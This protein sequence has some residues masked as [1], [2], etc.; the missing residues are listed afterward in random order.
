VAAR[1][2]D[3]RREISPEQFA[4]TAL[5]LLFDRIGRAQDVR[6]AQKIER[7]ASKASSTGMCA[8]PRAP[9]DPSA[10]A[11]VRSFPH[12]FCH[13][14]RLIRHGGSQTFVPR[15]AARQA[16]AL[17]LTQRRPGVDRHFWPP[18][19]PETSRIRHLFDVYN[20]HIR[21]FICFIF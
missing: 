3:K 12:S 21:I 10:S 17:K 16:Y 19:W 14:L 1:R 8:S 5:R 13:Q 15:G 6:R 18:V 9:P 2:G 11:T 4:K 20:I 7:A